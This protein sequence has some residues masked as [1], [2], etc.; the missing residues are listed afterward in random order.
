MS[1]FYIITEIE[2]EILG[3]INAFFKAFYGAD[4]VL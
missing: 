1:K 4:N 3:R 2:C